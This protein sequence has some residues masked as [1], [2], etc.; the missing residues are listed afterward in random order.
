MTCKAE[1]EQ[2]AYTVYLPGAIIIQIFHLIISILGK[3]YLKLYTDH[4]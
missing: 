2:E 1:K 4:I 3:Y